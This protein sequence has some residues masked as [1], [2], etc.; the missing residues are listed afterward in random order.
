MRTRRSSRSLS[1]PG[2]A[3]IK[4]PYPYERV[5]GITD[6]KLQYLIPPEGS[7]FTDSSRSMTAFF[8][9]MRLYGA[10][11]RLAMI[12]AAAQKWGVD[13]NEC[14]A[15]ASTRFTAP[16][17]VPSTTARL[18]LERPEAERPTYDDI[19]N[20]LKKPEEWRYIGKGEK[21]DAV[22]DAPDMVH[23]KGGLRRRRRSFPG[24]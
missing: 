9:V 7:Q 14:R 4:L 3:E 1:R 24:C 17:A 23:R 20:A 5:S 21:A 15:R 18:L 10:G 11:L 19:I 8:T 22:L 6:P 16:A 12:R 13:D 2:V